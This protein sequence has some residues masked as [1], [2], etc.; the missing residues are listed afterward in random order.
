ML[1]SDIEPIVQSE[2]PSKSKVKKTL[3]LTSFIISVASPL[4][5]GPGFIYSAIAA[6]I[7]HVAYK[8]EKDARIWSTLGIIFGWLGVGVSLLFILVLIPLLGLTWDFLAN[9]VEEFNQW[10]QSNPDVL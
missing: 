3:S 10:V 4:I 5:P 1:M 6:I 9:L 7:G 8:K 2:L